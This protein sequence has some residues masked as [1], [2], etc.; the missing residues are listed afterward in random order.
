MAN[1]A[2]LASVIAA[3]IYTNNNNEVTAE[4]VKAA[5][6]AMIASLGF[7]YQFRGVADPSDNPGFPDQ[8]VY[9]LAATP[10]RY[11]GFGNLYVLENEVAVLKWDT[12][13][14]KEVLD[15]PS[16][17]QIMTILSGQDTRIDLQDA[18]IAAQTAEI[19]AFKAAVAAQIASYP[20]ITIEGNV[21]NAPDEEDLTTD[22]NDLLKF[23]NR[24]AV[25]GLGYIILRKSDSFAD[26]VT[27]LNTIYE[28]RYDFDLGG[29]SV[30][31]P[32]GCV[33][34]FNG[35][36][37]TNGELVF[38]D[39]S[40]EGPAQILCDFSGTIT[41]CA[42]CSWFGA[43]Q[44][45]PAFDN[46][47]IINKVASVF[48]NICITGDT[49]YFSTPILINADRDERNNR[50]VNFRA[51]MFYNGAPIDTSAITL[52]NMKEGNIY[53]GGVTTDKDNLDFTENGNTNFVAVDLVNSDDCHINIRTIENANIGFRFFGDGFGCCY[54]HLEVG[55]IRNFNHGIRF[56]QDKT[57][58]PLS[59]T[60]AYGWANENT[61][62]SVRFSEH[63]TFD[64]DNL[65]EK[66]PIVFRGPLSASDT[67]DKCNSISI[68]ECSAENF[69]CAIYARNVSYMNI[70]RLRCEGTPLV[71]KFVGN[72]YGNSFVDSGFGYNGPTINLAAF[73]LS[74]ATR[75]PFSE[76]STFRLNTEQVKISTGSVRQAVD[77]YAAFQISSGNQP[78]RR[79][80][81]SVAGTTYYGGVIVDVASVNDR[82]VTAKGSALSRYGIIPLE[83]VIG[84]VVV[85]DPAVLKTFTPICSGSSIFS[86]SDIYNF[87]QLGGDA[88]EVAAFI[89]SPITKFFIGYR[90]TQNID[91]AFTIGRLILGSQTT[92]LRHGPTAN[93]PSV[94]STGEAGFAY[95]DETIAK[96]IVWSG[97]DWREADGALAGVRRTGTFAQKPAAANIYVGFAY[98][99]TD[100]QTTEGATNGIP[101][102]HKGSDVWVDAMGRTI[103]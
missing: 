58:G 91:V 28:I 12:T 21:N 26:Q 93:R 42:D 17:S 65:Y 27:E 47:P 55:L 20:M 22:A 59:G 87:W 30:T 3:N 46:G 75:F 41:G 102:Y 34:K 10:G 60:S 51:T 56:Y 70:N 92:L 2:T 85:T 5:L 73:D 11:A 82:I 98:F 90:V 86:W 36:S 24:S 69:A 18:D 72:G 31:I 14:S 23:K 48:K 54:N 44:N 97:T 57:N 68:N 35:G 7:G 78:T 99:C 49:F 52:A 80:F 61:L 19:E 40:I 43:K 4:M 50:Y 101:I 25:D 62:L 39:T 95:F 8:R 32:A 1:Y 96:D 63:S 37:I 74:E 103:S 13:W 53:I 77:G 67:Y 29:N 16:K 79:G 89:P 45:D 88:T 33:L 100:K 94:L 84:G 9:Y 66:I 76:L 6:D 38:T 83:A 15:I 81:L 64:P 71:A